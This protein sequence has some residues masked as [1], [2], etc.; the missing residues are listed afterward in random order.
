MSRDKEHHDTDIKSKR[1]QRVL[2]NMILTGHGYKI[3]RYM[4]KPAEIMWTRMQ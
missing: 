3:L 4:Q 2:L 1:T